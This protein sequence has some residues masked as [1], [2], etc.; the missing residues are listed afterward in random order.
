M[1]ASRL[2]V[3]DLVQIV[4]AAARLEA[5]GGDAARRI[6]CGIVELLVDCCD[7]STLSGARFRLLQRVGETQELRD[8]ELRL[9]DEAIALASR[10][11]VRRPSVFVDEAGLQIPPAVGA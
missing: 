1:S 6:R 11:P 8:A 10:S 3:S 2:Q 9:V 4:P 7:L 5:T